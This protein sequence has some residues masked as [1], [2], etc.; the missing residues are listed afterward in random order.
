MKNTIY[1]KLRDFVKEHHGFSGRDF[2][3][4]PEI[5]IGYNEFMDKLREFNGKK[6]CLKFTYQADFMGGA[7]EKVG[8]IK[9]EGKYIKFYEGR[10][11][12]K[13]NY[14]DAGL[15]EGFYATLI[16]MEVNLA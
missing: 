7:G 8:K 6:V 12:V 1:T 3:D 16:P 14:L 4:H 2:E 9:A 15:F 10:Y 13:F 11:R 5:M